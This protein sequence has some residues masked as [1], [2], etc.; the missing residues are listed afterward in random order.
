MIGEKVELKCSVTE[1]DVASWKYTSWNT[2]TDADIYLGRDIITSMKS[3]YT[4]KKNISGQ[5]NLIIDSADLAHAGRYQCTGVQKAL[6]TDVQLIVIGKSKPSYIVHV[7]TLFSL[8]AW[9]FK[10]GLS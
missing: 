2:S 4:I 3:R 8:P 5:H 7:N 9:N 1:N 10:L 6:I